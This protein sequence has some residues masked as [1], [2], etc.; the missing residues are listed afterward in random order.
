MLFCCLHCLLI[1]D[2][3]GPKEDWYQI[4][5]PYLFKINITYLLTPPTLS[6][7]TITHSLIHSHTPLTHSLS[8]THSTH[9]LSHSHTPLTHSLTHSLTLSLTHSLTHSHTPL[10]HSPT[11]SLTHSLTLTH[12]LHSL[13]LSLTRI[14]CT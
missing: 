11:H 2:K 9:S 13:T 4:N 7:T 3:E 14:K 10:T 1:C 8:P 6:H 12:T 5:L